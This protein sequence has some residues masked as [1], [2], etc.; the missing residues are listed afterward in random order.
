M[1]GLDVVIAAG[2]DHD[3][4]RGKPQ[5]DQYPDRAAPASDGAAWSLFGLGGNSPVRIGAFVSPRKSRLFR[6]SGVALVH[7]QADP[8]VLRGGINFVI[9][10]SVPTRVMHPRGPGRSCHRRRMPRRRP[11]GGIGPAVRSTWRSVRPG[12]SGGGRRQALA[13]SGAI[14]E[15][16][17]A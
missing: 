7:D 17:R 4:N 13:R 11:C 15:D 16:F 2:G 3:F 1:N 8:A 9:R 12:M 10:A 14:R 5:P 6:T